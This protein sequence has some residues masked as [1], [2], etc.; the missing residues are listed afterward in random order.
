MQKSQK[1]YEKRLQNPRPTR[2]YLTVN[3]GR[4]VREPAVKEPA[5]P[6]EEEE[7]E[8]ANMRLSI[9]ISCTEKG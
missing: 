9:A 5:V 1:S 6:I 4:S 2:K 3:G 7:P 8:A